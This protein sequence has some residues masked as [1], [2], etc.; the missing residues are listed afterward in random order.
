MDKV[1]FASKYLKYSRLKKN[2]HGIHSPFVFGLYNYVINHKAHYYAYPL[3]D[4]IRNE[5]LKDQRMISIKDLGAGS[6]FGL[7]DKRKIKQIAKTS[8]KSPKHARLLFR[9]AN[10]FQPKTIL[11]IGTSLGISTMHLAI[12]QAKSKVITIE[13]CPETRKIALENFEKAGLDNIV[14]HEGNFDTLLPGILSETNQLD[15]VFFDGNHRK[16]PTLKYFEMCLKKAGNE[17]VFIFDDIYWSKE[18]AD[19]WE[20]IKAHPK[21]TVSI[22]L[23][24]LGIVFFRKEQAKEHFILSY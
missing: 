5:L 12:A 19:A 23:F 20:T 3:L 1:F 4:S 22:D 18:M 10:H 21:V 6:G 7:R 15:L 24:Q 2:A 13:G 9:L 8:A 17:S 11:E 14:S 16:E